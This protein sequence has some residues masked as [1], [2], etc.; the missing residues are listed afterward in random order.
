ME[1]LL[2]NTYFLYVLAIV[3]MVT[4]F[5]KKK[6]KGET[7]SEI[8]EYFANHF[9]STVLAYIATTIGFFGYVYLTGTK[10]P[11]TAFLIGYTFDS[12]FNK[13]DKA[14]NEQ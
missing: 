12:L 2:A 7:T 13:W 5:L 4:H 9:K 14:K 8:K 11:V 3:G 10:E 6:V 1:T